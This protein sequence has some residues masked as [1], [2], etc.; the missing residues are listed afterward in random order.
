[1]K[2]RTTLCVVTALVAL[3]LTA[4]GSSGQGASSL[5]KGAKVSL[6]WWTGQTENS[7][8]IL[9]G[10]AAEFEKAHPNVSIDVS[11]GASSTDDLL[12]KL[13]AGFV[14]NSYPDISYAYGS[15]ASELESS[16]RTLDITSRVAEPDV[17]WGEFPEG[18]RLT[19]RP[20]GKKTIGFPA[21]VDNLTLLYNKTV[22]D[23]AGVPYPTDQWTWDDLRAAA[24][25]LTNP[26]TSTYGYAYS[27]S[28]AENTVWKLWPELW[29]NGGEILS[30][31]QKTAAF[32]SEAGVKALTLLRDMAVTD[33]SVYL[34][35]TDTKYEQ[36]FRNNRIGMMLSG[37]WVL[38]DLKTAQTKY[39]VTLLPGT[40]GDHQTASGPDLWALF[41]H[42]DENRAYWAYEFANWLTSA[43]QDERWNV[44]VGNLPLRSSEVGSAAFQTQVK[45]YPGLDV[46]AA[47]GANAKKVRPTVSGYVGLSQAIGAAISEVLQGRADPRPALEKAAAK[48]NTAL[49]AAR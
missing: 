4:C 7:E 8:K 17:K 49:E 15:W 28:G 46:M 47:N 38:Y 35:Q 32:A 9:E 18:A 43:A 22:F 21:V 5:D 19:A 42:H 33:K 45:T 24:K 6:S 1:M 44:A 34:D 25:K 29:Q 16:G 40:N 27:V 26:A 31:D 11:P 37:P 36:L 10:L 39:G 30:P 2:R 23:G 48:A 41:D 20:T 12:Q 13:S 14:G 3:A